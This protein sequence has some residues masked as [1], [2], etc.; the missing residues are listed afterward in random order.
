MYSIQSYIAL[1]NHIK[2]SLKASKEDI[3]NNIQ[4]LDL[5]IDSYSF[6]S[7]ENIN[8]LIWI[9]TEFYSSEF[10]INRLSSN[11]QI[12]DWFHKL[13]QR[14]LTLSCHSHFT[15]AYDRSLLFSTLESPQPDVSEIL[16]NSGASINHH[17]IRGMNFIG[18]VIENIKRL[19]F[20]PLWYRFED[21]TSLVDLLL[22]R[23]AD[24]YHPYFGVNMYRK[25][26]KVIPDWRF[27]EL[28]PL[29]E[30]QV[31]YN[32]YGA[33]F[34][35][36]ILNRTFDQSRLTDIQHINRDFDCLFD[37]NTLDDDPYYNNIYNVV[38]QQKCLRV[39]FEIRPL[40]ESGNLHQAFI[41][42][43][44]ILGSDPRDSYL[45]HNNQY[46]VSILFGEVNRI[47]LSDIVIRQNYYNFVDLLLQGADPNRLDFYGESMLLNAVQCREPEICELLINRGAEVNIECHN[48]TALSEAAFLYCLDL[49][50][51][52][53]FQECLTVLLANNAKT[54]NEHTNL[55]QLVINNKRE[56]RPIKFSK[57]T[58]KSL[59]EIIS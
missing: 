36:R 32:M 23:N 12:K 22:S 28:I 10:Q 55:L 14:L 3:N 44:D 4:K 58:I 21:V 7:N 37:V 19:I 29:Y 33:P 6:E 17:D 24:L 52:Q 49:E 30:I 38:S 27:A 5:L 59:K 34:R 11:K 2:R 48:H 8:D 26:T 46:F 54:I 56:Y 50:Y 42:T 45:P 9:L 25:G 1:V 47:P 15:D 51:N 41:L 39:L 57:R 53:P 35:K 16:I 20:R 43:K 40:V 31:L 18:A 13:I